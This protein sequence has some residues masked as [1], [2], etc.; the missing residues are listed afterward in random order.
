MSG[1]LLKYTWPDGVE[2]SSEVNTFPEVRD[3]YYAY[4]QA[5]CS[6]VEVYVWSVL[7]DGWEILEWGDKL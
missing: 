2:D 5:G 6:N 3:L 4:K 7:C 1:Y